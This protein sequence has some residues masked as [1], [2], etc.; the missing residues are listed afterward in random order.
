MLHRGK[1]RITRDASLE[2]P[3]QR[4]E[5]FMCTQKTLHWESTFLNCKYLDVYKTRNTPNMWTWVSIEGLGRSKGNWPLLAEIIPNQIELDA[6]VCNTGKHGVL[7]DDVGGVLK[8]VNASTICIYL[9][10]N[11]LVSR[12]KLSTKGSFVCAC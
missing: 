12:G 6:K 1:G 7:H 8:Q 5:L 10:R 4:G 11:L 2:Q 9:P 3:R